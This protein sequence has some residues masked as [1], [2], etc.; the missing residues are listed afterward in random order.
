MKKI[1]LIIMSFIGANVYAQ[2]LNENFSY[3]TGQLTS[4]S[5][6]ANVS[7][8]NWVNFSGTANPLMVTTGTITYSGYASSGTG[9]QLSTIATSASAEDAYRQFATQ[10]SGTVYASFLLN[11]TDTARL[12]DSSNVTG[13]YFATYLPSSSTSAFF[14]RLSIR[15]GTG[16]TF[17]L[18]IRNSS[19]P[20]ASTAWSTASYTPGTTYLVVMS[21]N[22]ISG[23]SN[24]SSYLWVNPSLSSSTPP[25]PAAAAAQSIIGGSDPA[26]IARIAIRQGTNTPNAT[27]DG[28]RVGTA[29]S[30]ISGVGGGPAAVT[31]TSVSPINFTTARVRWTKPGTYNAANQTV[32]VYMKDTSAITAGTA[33]GALTGITA[34]SNFTGSGST[35]V[36]DA[37]A[38]CIYKGDGDSV[39]VSGLAAGVTYYTLVLVVDTANSTNIYSSALTANATQPR[40]QVY[41]TNKFGSAI[42]GAVSNTIS[43]SILNPGTQTT[44]TTFVNLVLSGGDATNGVDLATTFNTVTLKFPGNSTAAQTVSFGITNDA[45]DE[46][47]ET[48]QFSL[49]NASGGAATLITVDSVF[50]FTIRDN[51]GILSPGSGDIVFTQIEATSSTSAPVTY[52]NAEFITLKRLDLRNLKVTDN[53]VLADNTLT[54]NEGTYSLPTSGYLNDVPAGTVVRFIINTGT[55]DTLWEDGVMTFYASAPNLSSSGDQMIAYTGFNLYAAGINCGN[56]GWTSGSTSTSTSKAPG[57]L[58]DFHA[59]PKLNARFRGPVSG[60][61]TLLRDSMIAASN[62]DTSSTR[63]ASDFVPVNALFDEPA[64]QSAALTFSNIALSSLNLN[65]TKASSNP[66]RYVV[67]AH[68]SSSIS[69]PADSFTYRNINNYTQAD[70][71]ITSASALTKGTGMVVYS[72]HDTSVT[73]TGLNNNTRYYFKVFAFNG[74]GVDANYNSTNATSGDTSTLNPIVPVVK[75][76]QLSKTVTEDSS[77]VN[78]AVSISN[79]NSNPTSVTVVTKGGTATSGGTDYTLNTTTVTFPANSTTAQNVTVAIANDALVETAETAIFALRNATNSATIDADS[80]FTLTINDNDTAPIVT[81]TQVNKTVSEDSST[82]NLSV[83]IQ[84]PSATPTSVTVVQK[85]GTAT[86]GTDYVFNTQTVTFPGGSSTPQMVTFAVVNDAAFELQEAVIL[87]LRNPTNQALLGVDSIMTVYI[88]DN[89]NPQISFLTS[90]ETHAEN[91]DTIRIPVKLKK[92]DSGT[93]TVTVSAV[94][95]TA[96]ITSDYSLLTTSLT[97]TSAADTMKEIVVRLNRSQYFESTE[98]FTVRLSAPTNNAIVTPIGVDTVYITN[99]LYPE[100][101]IGPMT[102]VD[103]NGV[104]DSLNRWAILKGTVYGINNRATGTSFTIRDYSGGITVFNSTKNFGYTVNQGDSVF[105][106]GQVIQFNGLT[107]LSN[108]DTIMPAGTGMPIAAPVQVTSLT[109]AAENNLV[110]FPSVTLADTTQWPVAPFTGSG[111]NLYAYING[112]PSD[113]FQIR[114]I[115]TSLLNGSPLPKQPFAIIGLGTQFD[116]SNPFTSGYQLI[117]QFPSHIV[118]GDTLS[119]AVSGATVAEGSGNKTVT[120]KLKN[121]NF[122]PTSVAVAVTGGNAVAGVDYTY[123]TQVVTFAAGSNADQ[124]ITVTIIDDALFEPT[125][126]TIVLS[127]QNP[128]NNAWI[129]AAATTYTLVITDNDPNGIREQNALQLVLYPNPAK[130]TVTVK[131]DKNIESIEVADMVGNIVI[132]QNAVQTR[133]AELNTSALKAGIYF[134][135]VYGAGAVTVKK[136]VIE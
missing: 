11:I 51:D 30:D 136:V 125:P 39:L 76:A 47:D 3:S 65:W 123:T 103:A 74:N 9:N 81:F 82:V 84:Y 101:L 130:E 21:H 27:I 23:T 95:G 42:E 28:I 111:K 60:V 109:E 2:I 79:P 121:S 15:R 50:N 120:I 85:A 93:Y 83:S 62:W 12:L 20:G 53:G 124:T 10:T 78:I 100:R 119:F 32:L 134:V 127:L 45:S 88:N 86:P 107:E 105:A 4:L 91:E 58:A 75:F 16:N 113:S 112:N 44:D 115:G 52:D 72:G 135:R 116:A 99:W 57:T 132:T 8:G 80:V 7:G 66:Q 71:V 133:S 61:A 64:N 102:T 33:S 41:F 22:F 54:T 92:Y 24:D 77:S 128:T 104:T 90:G 110:Y 36:N 17:N 46:W 114:I 59:G 106:Y 38:K 131:S 118:P 122:F 14:S 31:A 40:T 94:A 1:L 34:D 87:A 89:D 126:D 70:T 43:V 37:E 35:W 69:S 49:R 68:T 56:S 29:W 129:D 73:V 97:F 55:N 96:V 63:F 48:L 98:Y 67:V 6:G 19:T 108:L 18:G 25:T 5:A 26:D 13:D 117:P